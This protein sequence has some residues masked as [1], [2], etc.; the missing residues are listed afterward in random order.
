MIKQLHLLG[1]KYKKVKHISMNGNSDK[2]LILRQQFALKFLDIDH[3]AKNILNLDETWLNISDFRRMHW[4][5][6]QPNCSI[7]AKK[8]APRISMITGV[9]KLGNIYLCLSQSNSNKSMM[10]LFMEHL[11][12]KLDK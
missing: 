6:A 4:K 5:Y 3:K 1:L 2:S 10:G 11:V 8:I 9:D 12:V 7:K